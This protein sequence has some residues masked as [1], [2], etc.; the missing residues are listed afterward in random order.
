MDVF[1]KYKPFRNKISLLA[2]EDA[3]RVIW[4]YS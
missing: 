2:R 4:A 3:L 1:A